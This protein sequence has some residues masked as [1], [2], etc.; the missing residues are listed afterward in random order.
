MTKEKGR[1][2]A[3]KALA[4]DSLAFA[5]GAL[6]GFYLAGQLAGQGQLSFSIWMDGYRR[7]FS[8]PSGIGVSFLEVFWCA[9]RWPL[10]I[11]LLGFTGLG[12]WMVPTMFALRGFFLCFC[13]AG[14][15]S[16]A[17]G[18]LLLA[19]F[20]FGF[21][22]LV[23]LPI[24]FLLGGHAWCQAVTWRG[25]LWVRPGELSRMYWLEGALALGC[26][27]CWAWVECWL[28]PILLRQLAP[29]LVGP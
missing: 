8:L 17:Q 10:F 14:L 28:L 18:G 25:R 4:V 27:V 5:L 9:V 7:G 23:T 26:I 13:V 20:L 6:A 19:F 12:A 21:S 29:V 11:W 15:S 3:S 22:A 1:G 24:F 16:S 2:C